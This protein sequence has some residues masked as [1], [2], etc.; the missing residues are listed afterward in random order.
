MRYP[1]ILHFVVDIGKKYRKRIAV[2]Y[3]T[4]KVGYRNFALVCEEKKFWAGPLN[5]TNFQDGDI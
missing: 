4:L 1:K 2:E 5:E 3:L